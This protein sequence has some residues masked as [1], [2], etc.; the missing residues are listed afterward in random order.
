MT[1][2]VVT[3]HGPDWLNEAQPHALSGATTPSLT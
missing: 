3:H 2:F 1:A